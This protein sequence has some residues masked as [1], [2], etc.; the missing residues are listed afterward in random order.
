MGISRG[1]LCLAVAVAASGCDG[2]PKALIEGVAC[3]PEAARRWI[4]TAGEDVAAAD[5]AGP[6]AVYVDGSASMAGYLRGDAGAG[7]P[8][9]DVIGM[10]PQM[11][12]V[13]Q[14]PVELVRFDRRVSVI[15]PADLRRLQTPEGYSCAPGRAC[16]AQE[17]HVDQALVRMAAA[18]RS[19]LSVMVSDL[20]L[21]NSE[22]L[23]SGGVALS[24]PLQ[25]ILSSGRGVAVYGFPSPYRGRLYD[26]PSGDR[27]VDAAGRYLFVVAVGTPKRLEA[28]H[29]SM[30]RAPSASIASDLGAG[31]AGYSLF[32]T[33]PVRRVVEGTQAFT[34]PVRGPLAKAAF[35]PVR[36]GVRLPQFKLDRGAALRAGADAPGVVWSGVSPSEM[37]TGAVWTGP[38]RGV[39][40]TFR[41][42]G[43]SCKPDGGDW[44]PEGRGSEGWRG[45]GFA[46]EPGS[47]AEMP[48]GT[49]LL[50]GGLRRTGL[51]SPNPATA[52]MREWSFDASD[53]KAAVR[54]RVV[55]TLNLSETARLM[56]NALAAAA[57]A[58][59]TNIGGFAVAV[60]ID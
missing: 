50:V 16:D 18:D 57:E 36:S 33:E 29:S 9:A 38:S 4:A 48:R 21:T 39:T 26:L 1:P 11:P 12:G 55:P 14:G 59:P 17:S 23:T 52:W 7:R 5:A 28:F 54:R 58:R 32:T 3:Y 25:D 19:T 46:L 53:E 15:S 43:S 35:L 20:W 22:V 6:Y 10:L 2:S 41:M 30:L 40:A 27:S 8:L 34:A 51:E 44:R 56:E 31:R 24:K 13:S 45:S 47:L 37:R 60:Q 49:Y 42:T